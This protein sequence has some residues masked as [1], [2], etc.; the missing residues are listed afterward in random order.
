VSSSHINKNCLGLILFIFKKLF[1]NISVSCS[2]LNFSD[3][4]GINSK[5]GTSGIIRDIAKENWL[6]AD[7]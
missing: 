4:E 3:N 2:E 7:K 1:S 5:S 6:G